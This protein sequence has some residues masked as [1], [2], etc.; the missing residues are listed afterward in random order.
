M[1]P[2]TWVTQDRHRP[3]AGPTDV[4]RRPVRHCRCRD[5]PATAPPRAPGS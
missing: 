4:P 1:P 2:Y 5:W 3:G